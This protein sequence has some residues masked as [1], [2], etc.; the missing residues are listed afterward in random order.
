MQRRFLGGFYRVEK[1]QYFA[2]RR[3]KKT[4]FCF[5]FAVTNITVSQENVQ[6][7]R[8]LIIVKIKYEMTVYIPNDI[9]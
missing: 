2:K 8:L 3:H 1:Y 9:A 6:L 4:T 5:I 7:E